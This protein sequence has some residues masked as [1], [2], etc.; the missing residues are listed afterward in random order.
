MGCSLHGLVNIMFVM[1]MYQRKNTYCCYNEGL[2]YYHLSYY[3]SFFAPLAKGQR[4]LCHSRSSVM[5]V[6]VNYFLVSGIETT[7]LNQSGLNLHEVFMGTRSRMRSIVSKIHPV[8]PEL[9]P[10]KY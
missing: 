1:T 9:L 2:L 10:L 4:G 8:I 3:F 7:F 6:S 5:P